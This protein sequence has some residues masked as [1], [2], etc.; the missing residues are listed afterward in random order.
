MELILRVDG[1]EVGRELKLSTP[2]E[3]LL[4]RIKLTK[5]RNPTDVLAHQ[6][7]QEVAFQL[8]HDDL[9]TQIVAE[10]VRSGV[11]ASNGESK[12]RNP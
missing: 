9:L 4:R 2:F 8:R 12:E 10:L 5:A 7:T 11:R 6:I 3:E 1:H